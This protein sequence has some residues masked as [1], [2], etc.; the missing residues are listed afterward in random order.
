VHGYPKWAIRSFAY[1]DLAIGSAMTGKCLAK[2]TPSEQ[3]IM[4]KAIKVSQF[5]P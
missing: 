3:T 1:D 2:P 4:E 5:Q